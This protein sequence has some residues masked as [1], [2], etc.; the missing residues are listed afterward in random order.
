MLEKRKE[1]NVEK[2]AS[3]AA[4]S[5]SR[6]R[7]S[8]SSAPAVIPKSLPKAIFKRRPASSGN[9][10]SYLVSWS[11]KRADPKNRWMDVVELVDTYRAVDATGKPK[12][13]SMIEAYDATLTTDDFLSI[14]AVV[15]EKASGLW[16][17]F[18]LRVFFF[19]F[20][21]GSVF[22]WKMV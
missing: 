5:G 13:V 2:P 17:F 7:S 8:S 11:G 21:F 22:R 4:V 9:F 19:F 12:I 6:K 3:G 18:F 16:M 20:K 10:V 15:D 14:Y 1:Q